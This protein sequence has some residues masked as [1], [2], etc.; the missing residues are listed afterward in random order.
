MEDIAVS[1]VGQLKKISFKFSFLF[2]FSFPFFHL[3]HHWGHFCRCLPSCL[4]LGIWAPT[5]FKLKIMTSADTHQMSPDK[6]HRSIWFL[7]TWTL[8]KT[9]TFSTF[10][11]QPIYVCEWVRFLPKQSRGNVLQT[12]ADKQASG[13]FFHAFQ[14]ISECLTKWLLFPVVLCISWGTFVCLS[15]SLCSDG[16]TIALYRSSCENHLFV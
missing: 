7:R 5:V 11:P 8:Q 4:S 14:W 3:T 10:Y 16:N 15:V 13:P 6:I 1:A 2:F 9:S 12:K